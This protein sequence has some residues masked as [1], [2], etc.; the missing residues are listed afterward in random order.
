MIREAVDFSPANPFL[1][2][3]IYSGGEA[4]LVQYKPSRWCGRARKT[5]LYFVTSNELIRDD[6]GVGASHNPWTNEEG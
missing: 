1:M 6:P 2:A 5:H 3:K 4:G